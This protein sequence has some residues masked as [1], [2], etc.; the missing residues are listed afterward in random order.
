L[1]ADRNT[2]PPDVTSEDLDSYLGDG[3]VAPIHPGIIY[4]DWIIRRRGFHVNDVADKAGISREMLHRILR[5]DASITARTAI[6][7]AEVAGTEPEFWLRAQTIFNLWTER[8]RR[9]AAQSHH[10][11]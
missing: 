9:K 10:A 6:G 7:L 4:R 11:Q 2:D 8:E 1:V 3:H 5:G